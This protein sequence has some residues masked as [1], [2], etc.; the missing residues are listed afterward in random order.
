MDGVSLL[1]LLEDPSSDVREQM[2]FMNAWGSVPTQSLT[3]LT[4]D[5]KYTYWWYG[6]STMT[7]VEELFHLIND[8]LE[9]T[10]LAGNPEASSMLQ[11]M[12]KRYD[13]ELDKWK[14]QAVAYGNY[15]QYGTLFDRAIPSQ[16]KQY[17]A[18]AK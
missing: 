16:Q 18:G 13:V 17:K 9:M 8:P 3:V 2:A 1:P 10:N 12:R 5:A 7:P 11:S 4:R 15:Q 14:Q 6:D